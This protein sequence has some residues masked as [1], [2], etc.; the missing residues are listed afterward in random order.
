MRTKLSV[1]IALIA[2]SGLLILGYFFVGIPGTRESANFNPSSPTTVFD[3]CSGKNVRAIPFNDFPKALR[4]A[5]AVAEPVRLQYLEVARRRLVCNSRRRAL[6]YV[7]DSYRLSQ[8]LHFRFSANEIQTIYLNEMYLGNDTFGVESGAL[9]DAQ[10][11]A[12]DLS[13]SESALLVGMIRSTARYSP[14][15]YPEAARTRRNQ[16][17]DL[18]AAQNLISVADA[19]HA[20]A[21][22]LPAN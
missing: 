5:L 17:L 22:A 8:K 14:S 12:K 21:E 11:R 3:A 20:K 6:R 7:T 18:M 13:L 2:T 16:I 9:L 4:D 19:Q 15:K 1:G 10:K